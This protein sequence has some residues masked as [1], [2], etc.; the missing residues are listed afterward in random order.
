MPKKTKKQSKPL[1]GQAL[2]T[3]VK[4]LNDLTREE[5]AKACGYYKIAK[6]GT[7]RINVMAFLNAVLDAEGMDLDAQV[8]RNKKMGG[9]QPNYRISVQS[10]G[11]LLVSSAYTKKMELQPGDELEIALGRKHIHLRLKTEED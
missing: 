6:S 10:N 8:K 9:R 2:L 1:A 4:A 11:K 7:E 5:K 3:K